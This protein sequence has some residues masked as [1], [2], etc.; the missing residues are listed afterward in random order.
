MVLLGDVGR[1]E[2]C[3]SLFGDS[4]NLDARW[5]HSLCRMYHEHGN[6]FGHTQWNS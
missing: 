4:V 3:F 6:I 2:A 5:V 1:V